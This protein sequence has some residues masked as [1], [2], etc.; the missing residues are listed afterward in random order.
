MNEASEFTK[1]ATQAPPCL[2]ASEP[3]MIKSGCTREA[4]G[5]LNTALCVVAKPCLVQT[6]QNPWAGSPGTGL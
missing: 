6:R 5:S 2:P 3:A 1:E 4:P